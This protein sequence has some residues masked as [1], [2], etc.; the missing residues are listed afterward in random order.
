MAC[1]FPLDWSSIICACSLSC[2]NIIL[3]GFSPVSVISESIYLPLTHPSIITALTNLDQAILKQ[4]KTWGEC[5][6]EMAHLPKHS[7]PTCLMIS[8]V[9]HKRTTYLCF[10]EQRETQC[11]QFHQTHGRGRGATSCQL[12]KW[13]TV[14][15]GL[16]IM[17]SLELCLK[18]VA[19]DSK[20]I[21]RIHL[22]HFT[23]TTCMQLT[24][25]ENERWN[26]SNLKMAPLDLNVKKLLTYILNT[27]LLPLMESPPFVLWRNSN[28]CHHTSWVCYRTA[29]NRP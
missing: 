12:C 16:F 6:G 23:G 28:T 19:L 8:M 29:H 22:K 20:V 24:L 26:K 7:L 5:K 2:V 25:V 1:I 4:T 3:A 21:L 15:D 14:L 27:W 10:R 11:K 18:I 9:C 17:L 13:K